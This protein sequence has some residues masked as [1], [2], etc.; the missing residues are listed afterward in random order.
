MRWNPAGL[1]PQA[2]LGS[3]LWYLQRLRMMSAGELGYR[4]RQRGTLRRLE[5]SYRSRPKGNLLRESLPLFCSATERQLPAIPIHGARL[6]NLGPRLLAGH[7]DG[8]HP[9]CWRDETDVWH[10]APDSGRIWP[11][12]FFAN[13]PYRPGNAYGDIRLLW[14]PARLQHLVDLALYADSMSRDLRGRAVTMIRDQLLSWERANPPLDGPH[15]ISAMECGL[16][17]IAVCHVLDILRPMLQADDPIRSCIAGIAESH[18][19]LIDQRLSLYSSRGNHTM[20]EAA[21]LVYAGALFPEFSEAIDWRQTGL[22]LLAREAEH[23]VLPDGGGA[24]QAMSYHQVNLDLLAL[25]DALLRHRQMASEP[26]LAAAT[27]RGDAFVRSMT[28]PDGRLPDIGDGDHGVALARSMCRHQAKARSRSCGIRT[29]PHAGYTVGRTDEPRSLQWILDH[30]PLG[31][32]PANG[33]GHADALSLLLSVGETPLFIDSGTFLYGGDAQW[34]RYFRGTAAHNTVMVDGHD[35][36]RQTGAFLWSQ[37]Y[38]SCLL[39]RM[40]HSDGGGRLLAMHTGYKRLGVTHTRGMCWSPDGWLLVQDQLTGSGSHEIALH[41]H[42]PIA[43][44]PF[45][46]TGQRLAMPACK[47]VMEIQGGEVALHCG[48]LEPPLGWLSPEYGTRETVNT[49]L[50]SHRGPLPHC[51]ATLILLG[52]ARPSR[53]QTEEFLQWMTETTG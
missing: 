50:V 49:I 30:G 4:L 22:R 44:E 1:I 46:P 40:Q 3:L 52:E 15:Y 13:L 17:L 37:P 11:R 42:T 43:V 48:Q 7:L 28:L 9:W 16:R 34:R 14:E 51:F 26:R 47:V 8:A 31:M 21:A 18:A 6:R 53:H 38:T 41:W 33:H 19:T 36:A 5:A 25:V 2:G 32:P 24:E 10:R 45:T 20:A 39:S 23:Q 12:G 29:Y 27:H 35:Q